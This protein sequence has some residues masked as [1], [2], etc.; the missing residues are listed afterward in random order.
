MNGAPK[1]ERF[2]P[3][4][5]RR[6]FWKIMPDLI[7]DG[8]VVLPEDP[9][10]INDARAAAFSVLI[11]HQ[12]RELI[13]HFRR[14]ELTQD[15]FYTDFAV[16]YSTEITNQE[17]EIWD[18][19]E[20]ETAQK[21]EQEPTAP[22]TEQEAAYLTLTAADAARGI[23][24]DHPQ[25]IELY[26]FLPKYVESYEALLKQKYG[27]S[28]SPDILY[29]ALRKYMPKFMTR[30]IA[31]DPVISKIAAI[32]L[33]SEESLDKG[34]DT[35]HATFEP[36]TMELDGDD[37]LQFKKLFVDAIHEHAMEK[38]FTEDSVGRTEDRGCPALYSNQRDAVLK[39]AVEEMIAQHKLYLEKVQK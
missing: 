37:S 3:L 32:N 31:M 34:D 11:D 25:S 17:S 30:F 33:M 21:Q 19:F 10:E 13:E 14:P 1:N 16:S 4:P 29:E 22:L 8:V 39:F 6:E 7:K 2:K 12:E 23:P 5:M 27:D 9:K 38:N 15:D 36:R 26:E 20:K 24:T 18:R 35:A 28:Y